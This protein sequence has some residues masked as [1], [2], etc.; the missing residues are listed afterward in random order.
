[1]QAE[2]LEQMSKDVEKLKTD[3]LFG[4]EGVLN[5]DGDPEAVQLYLLALSHLDQAVHFAK[6]A[7]LRQARAV[8]DE[9]ERRDRRVQ[10]FRARNITE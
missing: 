7:A 1:M 8:E 3:L 4:R 9:A 10:E 5:D 2:A 6:I